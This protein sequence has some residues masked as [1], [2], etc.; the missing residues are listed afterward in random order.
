MPNALFSNGGSRSCSLSSSTLY[1]CPT[2]ARLPRLS[3]T[4]GNYSFFLDGS[5]YT[6]PIARTNYVIVELQSW[7]GGSS[8]LGDSWII[9]DTFLKK[10]YSSYATN[11]SVTFYCTTGTC[12]EGTAPATAQFPTPDVG[13]ARVG[14]A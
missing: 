14:S 7:G 8:S 13:G 4:F 9:G 6:L 2:Q 11:Q 5:D 1:V 3:F 10:F 12:A